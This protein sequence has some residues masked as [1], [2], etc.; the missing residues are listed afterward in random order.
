LGEAL[1]AA[2]G[3]SASEVPPVYE[4]ARQLCEQLQQTSQ[5]LAVLYGLF[6]YYYVRGEADRALEVALDLLTYAQKRSDPTGLLMGHKAVGLALF[7]Q[8]KQEP[9]RQ[10]M[11][12]ALG[13]YDAAPA[14]SHVFLSPQYH[15]A[16]V[17]AWL[18]LNLLTLGCV[19]EAVQRSEESLAEA[20]QTGLP[21]AQTYCLGVACR[22]RY[23]LQ[24]IQTLEEYTATVLTLATET[25]FAYS[26][27][28]GKLHRGWLLTS[29]GLADE[30]IALL[31]EHLATLRAM[32]AGLQVA[33]S[34][35]VIADAFQKAGRI[36][37]GLSLLDEGLREVDESAVH[38]YEA[39]LYR[40]K[41]QLLLQQD[42]EGDA[43]ERYL[44]EALAIARQQEAKFFELRA[45]T[46]LARL[47]CDQGKRDEARALLAP[48]YGWFTEGFDTPDLQEAKAL[49][50]ELGHTADGRPAAH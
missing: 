31:L 6:A 13:Y 30:G 28:N 7:S 4:R 19:N 45:A 27:T 25:G 39:E 44:G 41:G 2:K 5:L 48:V 12:A 50:N 20:W 14:H 33:Y 8:G 38:W 3:W 43:A 17:L 11:E 18:S 16:T 32:G 49:L 42:H 29:R 15:R 1:I 34:L 10:H 47:W 22:L 40:V 26:I 46:I 23:M 21:I 9:A 37:E 35:V 36:A 24:D